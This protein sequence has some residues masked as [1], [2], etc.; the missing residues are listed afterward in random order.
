MTHTQGI[1]FELMDH[2]MYTHTNMN[3]PGVVSDGV[4]TAPEAP[5][6]KTPVVPKVLT[7][8]EKWHNRQLSDVQFSPIKL[9]KRVGG[10][11]NEHIVVTVRVML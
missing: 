4:N 10:G 11:R 8:W 9:V 6:S 5:N 7:S 3:T 2:D 1:I